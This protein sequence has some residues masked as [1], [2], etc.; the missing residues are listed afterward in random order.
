MSGITQSGRGYQGTEGL[1]NSLL[2]SISWE[3]EEELASFSP[4]SVIWLIKQHLP[5]IPPLSTPSPTSPTSNPSS[6]TPPPPPPTPKVG[7]AS[8]VKL[9]VFKGVGNEESG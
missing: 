2:I 6:P 4:R 8:A 7:M 3:S 9:P 5:L 1:E